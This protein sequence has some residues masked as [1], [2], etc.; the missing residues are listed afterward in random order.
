MQDNKLYSQYLKHIVQFD[1]IYKEFVE[2]IELVQDGNLTKLC[3]VY[4]NKCIKAYVENKKSIAFF[5][6][7]R[8]FRSNFGALPR[9]LEEAGFAVL[10]FYGEVHND[11]FEN[12]RGSFFISDMEIE[13]ERLEFIDAFVTASIMN[14]LPRNPTK[15]LM[16]H[17]SFAIFFPSFKRLQN[18]ERT[19]EE[20]VDLK[21]FKPAFGPLYDYQFVSS[22]FVLEQV[23]Y[24][25]SLNG[26][27]NK[28]SSNIDSLISN[29][30]LNMYKD[31]VYEKLDTQRI[32][33]RITLV[34]AGYSKIDK[35]VK[36][37]QDKEP[38]EII[39]YAPTPNDVRNKKA[40]LP[41]MS[42]NQH[43]IDI[44]G[45]LCKSFPEHTI[46]F[47]P[48]IDEN[49]DIVERIIN[50][51]KHYPNFLLVN[52]ENTMELYSKTKI[53]VSDLSSTAFTFSLSTLRPTIFY[54]PSEDLIDTQIV[55]HGNYIHNREKIGVVTTNLDSLVSEIKKALKNME[56]IS[57]QIKKLRDE[58]LF[59]VLSSE[60]VIFKS[61]AE[62]VLN[63]KLQCEHTILT[64]IDD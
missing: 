43:G 33:D 46:V 18:V 22:K 60:E 20:F 27:I 15:I 38:E 53:M 45:Q 51:N 34:H 36:N 32:V 55:D 26:Y 64:K 35:Y 48:Y 5:C 50:S 8:S 1:K 54:S 40:W 31:V 16:D 24:E 13:K 28:K 12:H 7:T 3:A 30:K 2:T 44:V 29:Y 11:S 21:G 10:Y 19:Y 61:L 62:I 9:R 57:L 17:L 42:I 39:V 49:K 52:D 23:L 56:I 63:E 4:Q 59:N 47:K 14:C 41:L 25:A 6:P 37:N 58:Y